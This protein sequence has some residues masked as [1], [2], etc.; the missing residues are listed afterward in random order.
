MAACERS[1]RIGRFPDIRPRENAYETTSVSHGYFL[2]FSQCD[3]NS[4]SGERGRAYC[5]LEHVRFS[6]R[7]VGSVIR[8]VAILSYNLNSSPLNRTHREEQAVVTYFGSCHNVL[9]NEG[10]PT[11]LTLQNMRAPKSDQSLSTIVTMPI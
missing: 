8:Q 11:L 10:L 1:G 6:H 3:F 9:L 2:T 7:V 4:Q 5:Y